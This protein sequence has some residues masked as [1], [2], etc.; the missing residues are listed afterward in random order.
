MALGGDGAS[1]VAANWIRPTVGIVD[2]ATGSVRARRGIPTMLVVDA[3][4]GPLL[5]GGSST[6][7]LARIEPGSGR[8]TN[9][10]ETPPA[11]DAAL[12]PDGSALWLTVGRRAIEKPNEIGP[13]E[14]SR[15]L[16]RWPLD[17]SATPAGY[18][19]PASVR[20]LR[21][22]ARELWLAAK[23]VLVAVPLPVG[24]TKARLWKPPRD[25]EIAAF[26]PDERL[27]IVVHSDLRSKTAMA[28]AF[29]LG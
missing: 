6:G 12:E 8:L 22:G 3:R 18:F 9:L 5:V 20:E 21:L 25:H 16:R 1:V 2:L 28:T 14:P 15:V 19:L 11:I 7:G 4:T 13:G 10:A 23:D 24:E 29:D 17:G 26:D 27:A